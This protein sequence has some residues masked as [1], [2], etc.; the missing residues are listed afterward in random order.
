MGKTRQV[1]IG[2]S[3]AAL[4]AVRAIREMDE[5]CIITLISAENCNAYSPVLTTYYLSGR[6]PR[7]GL[8]IVAGDFYESKNVT[9]IF[10]SRATGLD[11]QKQVVFLEDGGEIE[12]DNLL[13]A[14]GASAVTLGEGLSNV[15]SL[16]T[17]EDTDRIR[18]QA[19]VARE[20][21]VIGG[22]LV[23]LQILNALVREGSRFTLLVSSKHLLSQS[24]DAHCAAIVQ[25]GI[26]SLGVDIR[27]GTNV[28]EVRGVGKK[29][30]VV[31]SSGEELTADL[32]LVGK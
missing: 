15:L 2:N 32:V 13:I 23:S 7:E 28:S 19:R 12:Y 18:E 11:P 22:G 4:S 26:E 16:R 1:I 25:K 31:T 30:A 6:I 9:T 24:I 29:A 27:F 5:E 14:T 20:V 10:G 17:V 21:I 8:F 3:A